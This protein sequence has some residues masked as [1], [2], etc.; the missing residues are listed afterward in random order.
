MGSPRLVSA[1]S[2]TGDLADPVRQRLAQNLADPNTLEGA[3]LAEVIAASGGGGGGSAPLVYDASTGLYTVPDS[4]NLTY[5][6][7]TGLYSTN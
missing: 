5:N 1:D 4:S 6:S 7:A 2:D 3:A